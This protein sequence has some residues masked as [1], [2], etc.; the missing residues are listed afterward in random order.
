[1]SPGLTA[2][3]IVD[4]LAS[5][6]VKGTPSRRFPQTLLPVQAAEHYTATEFQN[7]EQTAWDFRAQVDN[8]VDE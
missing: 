3:K 6:E 4:R 5:K 7:R 2:K 8:E 1:M